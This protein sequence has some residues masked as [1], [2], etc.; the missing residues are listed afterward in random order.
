V[1]QL[2]M[3]WNKTDDPQVVEGILQVATD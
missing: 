2:S 3:T 1:A